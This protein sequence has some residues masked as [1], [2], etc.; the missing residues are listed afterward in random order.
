METEE[1]KQQ[2]YDDMRSELESGDC[3]TIQ[4]G[5]GA[6]YIATFEGRIVHRGEWDECLANIQHC[7]SK[8]K[9]W[10]NLYY[11]NERGNVSL[12]NSQTGDEIQS[13]V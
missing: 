7:M 5:R 9:F 11:I 10:P 2:A 3:A 12:L 4:D 6:T 8:Q 13:W 1:D